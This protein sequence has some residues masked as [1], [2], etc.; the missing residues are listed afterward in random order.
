MVGLTSVMNYGEKKFYNLLDRIL[1]ESTEEEILSKGYT[2]KKIGKKCRFGVEVAIINLSQYPLLVGSLS[3]FEKI[4]YE[5]SLENFLLMAK[6][7]IV[8]A[9]VVGGGVGYFS[10]RKE[11]REVKK[12]KI[13]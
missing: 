10:A 8:G 5:V 4:N 11:I 2:I 3:I 6:V 13:F 9:I 7:T 1:K 12:N